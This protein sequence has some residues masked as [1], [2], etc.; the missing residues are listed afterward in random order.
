[1]AFTVD[2]HEILSLHPL[3][4]P[5]RYRGAL[6]W[7]I[8]PTEQQFRRTAPQLL[9]LTEPLNHE[10]PKPCQHWKVR[11]NVAPITLM[12]RAKDTGNVFEAAARD[13]RIEDLEVLIEI[14]GEDAVKVT[15]T[16]NA[17]PEKGGKNT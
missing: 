3:E 5:E 9:A 2:I 8:F 15:R 11:K 7:V 13:F 14:A 17:T 6:V 16:R 10:Q 1:M 12:V 4:R